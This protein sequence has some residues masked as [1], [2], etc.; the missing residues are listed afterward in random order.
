[1]ALRKEPK[2]PIIITHSTQ[3]VDA[4]KTLLW[5]ETSPRGEHSHSSRV[6]ASL[7]D[8]L[9]SHGWQLDHLDLWQHSLP[10]FNGDLLDAKYAVF[11]DQPLTP[12]QQSAWREVEALVDRY[13][14]AELVIFSFPMWNFGVPY[15]LKH[16]IDVITQPRLVFYFSLEKGYQS[17][18]TPKPA[19]LIHSSGADFRPPEGIQE[20]DFAAPF[21]SRWLKVY[22]AAEVHTLP[23]APTAVSPEA[24]E[25]T[26]S[27][28][29]EETRNLVT[30]ITQ[31]A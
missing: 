30:R 13:R 29:I 2:Q 16:F 9:Q 25:N 18:C 10:A 3:P 22:F 12:A 28:A 23:I 31:P 4:M 24:V 15:P 6:A 17:V 8:H 5:I 11:F 21:V 20:N 27:K 14:R 19:I 26:I 1:M 7:A